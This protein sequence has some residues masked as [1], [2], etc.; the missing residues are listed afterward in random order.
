M[1]ADGIIRG[2][3]LDEA[4]HAQEKVLVRLSRID[5]TIA[6]QTTTSASGKFLFSQ[7]PAG[8]YLLNAEKSGLT[9]PSLPLLVPSHDASRVQLLLEA[10]A[11][12]Q[13]SKASAP[14]LRFSDQPNFTIAGVTDWTAVGGHGSD[15]NLR[16]SEDLNREILALRPED[17]VVRVATSDPRESP[18]ERELR[19]ALATS[20]GSFDA[21]H[22]LG[23]FYLQNGNYRQSLPLLESAWRV[24]PNN[25]DNTLDLALACRAAGDLQQARAHMAELLAHRKNAEWIRLAGD[26]DEALGNPLAA[27]REYRQA[28]ELDPSEQNYFSWGSELLLHRAIWQAQEV[29]RKAAAA[30]P[31][32]VRIETGFGAALFA[33]ALYDQAGQRLCAASDLDPADPQP[34]LFMGQ[35]EIAAPDPLPC[36]EPKLARFARMQPGN[37]MADYLYAMAILKTQEHTSSSR[38]EEQGEALL[39]KAVA[40]DA[41]NAQAW[42]ELG[43]LASARRDFATAIDL[44]TRAIGSDPNLSDA[45]YRL[46]VA[47]DRSGESDKAR[48]EFLLHD[49][50][51]RSQAEAVERQRRSIQQFLFAAPAQTAGPPS[52]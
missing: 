45:Y 2:V 9:S 51:A 6:T 36:I 20:P 21:N 8:H 41:H 24:D 26:L 29:F 3:V 22:Q 14:A 1:L 33:G 30:Y 44:Y 34:Y 16:T 11:P 15:A 39:R 31:A 28:V 12:A 38:A 4:G 10:L 17:E 42:L 27:V 43:N 7:L 25:E 5:G 13:S 46:G 18:L 40:S 37:S 49:Q 50:I 19:S 23:E 47:Y 32:S 52:H 48:Q 35:I